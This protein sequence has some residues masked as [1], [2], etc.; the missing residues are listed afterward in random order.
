MTCRGRQRPDGVSRGHVLRQ[1]KIGHPAGMCDLRCPQDERV[2]QAD[3]E[4]VSAVTEPCQDTRVGHISTG[5][6]DIVRDGR[7]LLH[8]HPRDLHSQL[9]QQQGDQT[10]HTPHTNHEWFANSHS[11]SSHNIFAIRPLTMVLSVRACTAVPSCRGHLT[12]P[13]L[14][15][16]VD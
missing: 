1:I 2:G 4:R 12:R 5:K 8:V 14:R 10:A 6:L 11:A 13:A 9:A 3:N 16:G 7:S 15:V